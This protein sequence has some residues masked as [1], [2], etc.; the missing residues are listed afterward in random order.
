M[1]IVMKVRK[2]LTKI[3]FQCKCVLIFS[4]LFIFNNFKKNICVM[5][6][7]GWRGKM[8]ALALLYFAKN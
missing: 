1:Y 4:L 8:D 3:V 7:L 6:F 5:F 2:Y